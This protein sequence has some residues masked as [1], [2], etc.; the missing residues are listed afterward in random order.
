MAAKKKPKQTARLSLTLTIQKEF[1]IEWDDFDE[2]KQVEY[3]NNFISTVTKK[4]ETEGW[5]VS[6]ES[7]DVKPPN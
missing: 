6:L 4:L 1:P 3:E 2:D 5:D 7:S